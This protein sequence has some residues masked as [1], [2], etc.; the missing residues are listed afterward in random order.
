MKNSQQSNNRY[1]VV[2]LTG[3]SHLL[4]APRLIFTGKVNTIDLHVNTVDIELF[5]I[6]INLHK[7]AI[8][9][10]YDGLTVLQSYP[11]LRDAKVALVML[12]L[13]TS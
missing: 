10:P 2:V 6:K 4:N 3:V 13:I 7:Y 5:H 9:T 1:D 8:N 12:R 11:V